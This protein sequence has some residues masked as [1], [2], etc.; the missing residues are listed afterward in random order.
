MPKRL[1]DSGLWSKP[2]FRVLTPAEKCAFQFLIDHCDGAGVWDAD[3]EAAEFVIGD[4][5]DWQGLPGKVKDNIVVLD[6]GK[7]WLVDFVNF[8]CGG[9]VS[10]STT[11]RAHLSYLK[12]LKKHGLYETY[13]EHC[14]GTRNPPR[15]RPKEELRQAIFQRDN[16]TCQYCGNAFPVGELVPDHV[17]SVIAGGNGSED[18]LVTV[19]T[20]CNSRKIDKNAEEFIKNN[21][22]TP[23]PTLASIL[24]GSY[25]KLYGPLLGPKDNDN[26]NELDKDQ[27]KKEPD[28]DLKPLVQYYLEKHKAVRGFEPT[29]AWPRDMKIMQQIRRGYKPDAIRQLLDMF[30][31][32]KGRS[33]FTLRAFADKVDTLY[34]VLKD[35]AEGKR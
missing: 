8:Q 14:P 10:E 12:Q 35:K 18:N 2:W 26:D 17:V 5:V 25:G 34:G 9:E 23:G 6:N 7:W 22:L 28:H 19:C 30:F 3:F 16:F 21:N 13:V 33:N 1:H 32:W 20:P 27:D 31:A 24:N 15:I 29:V 4:K 11:N